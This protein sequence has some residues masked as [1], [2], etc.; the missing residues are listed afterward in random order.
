MVS[1]EVQEPNEVDSKSIKGIPTARRVRRDVTP[2]SRRVLS[3]DDDE[4]AKGEDGK[5]NSDG[6]T[7]EEGGDEDRLQRRREALVQR[8]RERT[9]DREKRSLE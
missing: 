6:N 4:E 8:I 3:D 9:A 2:F 5:D 7:G 1:F